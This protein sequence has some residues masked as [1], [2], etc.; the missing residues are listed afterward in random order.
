MQRALADA[1]SDGHTLVVLVGDEPYYARVGFKR[2]PRGRVADAGPGRSRRGSWWPS[3]SRAPSR[4]SK[5]RSGRTGRRLD[6]SPQAG[7][8]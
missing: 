5:A 7:E 3:W 2:V 6:P 8:G 1:K 4:A